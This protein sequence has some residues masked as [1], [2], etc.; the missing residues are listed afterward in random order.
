M[1]FINSDSYR[2]RN[3]CYYYSEKKIDV[4]KQFYTDIIYTILLGKTKN[5]YSSKQFV[6]IVFGIF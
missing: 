5:P 6:D 3:Y 2:L 1:N 4:L